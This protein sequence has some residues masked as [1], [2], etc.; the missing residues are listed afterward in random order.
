MNAGVMTASGSH[1]TNAK[2]ITRYHQLDGRGP[3]EP[4]PG[5]GSTENSEAARHISAPVTV[6]PDA[7][8][9]QARQRPAEPGTGPAGLT[10][11]AQS[12]MRVIVTRGREGGGEG[13]EGGG[14]AAGAVVEK[15]CS[16]R[17]DPGGCQVMLVLHQMK[18]ARATTLKTHILTTQAG[19]L[20]ILEIG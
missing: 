3:A 13:L 4:G 6:Q 14:A 11:T 2:S 9:M 5:W 20:P 17:V 15:P 16:V 8:T 1:T 19:D 7:K 12:G 18:P 10:G